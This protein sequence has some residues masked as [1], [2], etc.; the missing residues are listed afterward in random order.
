[1]SVFTSD[2]AA[3]IHPDVLAAIVRANDGRAVAYGNDDPDDCEPA[4]LC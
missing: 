1:M 3:G 2:N 4:S